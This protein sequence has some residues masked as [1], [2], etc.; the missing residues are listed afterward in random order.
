MFWGFL[1]NIPSYTLYYAPT[2][3][4]QKERSINI[5]EKH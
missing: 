1:T 4:S 2:V 5:E 3:S